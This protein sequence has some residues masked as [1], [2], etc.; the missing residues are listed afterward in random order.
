MTIQESINATLAQ[1]NRY[2]KQD[3][4]TKSFRTDDLGNIVAGESFV[5]P[6]DYVVISQ[7]IMRG[8]E[9]VMV[10]DADGNL[11]P[12][13]AEFIKVQ[14]DTG[15]VVNF[16][17]SALTKVAFR[18]DPETG[19][20]VEV[21]R[22][23]RPSGDLVAYVKNHPDMNAT[24]EALKGCTIKCEELTPIPVRAFGVSNEKATKKDV[25]TNNIGKWTLVGSQKPANWTV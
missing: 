14:T 22:I 16:F 15:R 6:N 13:T 11:I 4:F 5:V 24:M 21:D 17:P 20:D 19:K 12:A 18:V 3:G 1:S 7:R 10:K 2:Q 9:P 23:V 25:Q 8:G